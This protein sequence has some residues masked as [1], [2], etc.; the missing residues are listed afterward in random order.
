[1]EIFK[2]MQDYGHEEI[3][4]AHDKATDMKTIIAIHDTTLGPGL[5]GTR[6]WNYATEDDALYDV[7]R[8]SRG[9]SLKNAAA[10]IEFGGAKAVII[11]DP[12]KLKS[13]EFFHAYGKVV[14]SLN[15]KYVTGEDVNINTTDIGHIREVTTHVSGTEEIGGNPAPYTALGVFKGMKAGAKVLF[16]SDD[17]VGKV[18][19]MQGVGSVGYELCKMLHKEGA[20]LKVSDINA[21]AVKKAVDELGAIPI[22]KDE[23]LETECDIFSPCALG[24][25]LSVNNV[26]TLKCKM[27]C[28]AAN[29]PLVDHATCYELQ[30]RDI[31]FLPDYIVNGGGVITV[32]AE[33]VLG[34]KYNA[35]AVT[36]QVNRIYDTTLKVLQIAKEKGISTY[37][38][39]E[40][41]AMSIIAKGRGKAVNA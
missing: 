5:G 22:S 31:L 34:T 37:D 40:E 28:G 29:N 10:G 20:F 35:K 27:I 39:A 12:K 36:E 6:F 33:A 9:M 30:S 24:A 32:G 21:A 16:G 38:A 8:L 17:L 1:M 15:G 3:V 18:I 13:R 14:D 19:A 7:L 41:Y 2:Q 25:I 4:F 26:G 11:G 23:I